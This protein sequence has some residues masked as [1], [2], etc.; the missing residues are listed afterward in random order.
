MPAGSTI[1]D[2]AACDDAFLPHLERFV[3]QPKPLFHLALFFL[4]LFQFEA[5]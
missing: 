3:K 2:P 5:L 4:F 1:F